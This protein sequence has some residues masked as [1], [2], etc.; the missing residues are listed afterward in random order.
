MSLM[1]TVSSRA[2]TL[3]RAS[4][5]SFHSA[6]RVASQLLRLDS[7]DV[8]AFS[9]RSSLRLSCSSL[10]CSFSYLFAIAYSC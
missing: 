7:R 2:K 6:A 3:V 10:S 4:S 1:L 8:R 9:L 5:R